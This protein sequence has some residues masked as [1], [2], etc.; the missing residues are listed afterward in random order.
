MKNQPVVILGTGLAGYSV[1]REFRKLDP[2][3]PLVILTADDGRYYSKPVL[4]GAFTNGKTPE[5]IA[6][7]DMPAMAKQLSADIRVF[8]R[9]TAIHPDTKTIH[10]GEEMLEYGKLVLAIGADPIHI[11]V[12]GNAQD[13][14]MSVNDLTDYTHFRQAIAEAK[15][16]VIMGAG[17]IGC[18]FANDLHHGGIRVDVVDPAPFPLNRFLPEPV[19]RA[20]ERELSSRIGVRWR[21]GQT[22]K[23]VESMDNGLAVAFSD[24]QIIQTD[25]V[26]SS[27]GL[28][29][30]TQLASVAGI[31][32]N[33]GIVTDRALETSAP[34]VYALGD[35]AEVEGL[36]LPFVMP[37]MHAS[38]AL[39]K[40]LASERTPVSYPA[41]PILVKTTSYPVIISPPMAG[42][43]GAW[44]IQERESGIQALF[45]GEDK[46][47]QGFALTGTAVAEKNRLVKELP[48]VLN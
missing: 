32:I 26:L 8:S 47:L 36:V 11:P 29:P 48:S 31:R 15:H 17:L 20:I 44:E 5:T 37:I 42:A 7:A 4:S 43:L 14:V 19:G 46:T 24:N 30:R 39:A 21:L 2:Q 1:A 40:T 27:V 45:Y 13:R 18:E 35:C 9:V 22:I 33:R 16:L 38:R 28:R 6:I 12:A 25:G 10:I 41:M 3:S 23:S 34:D